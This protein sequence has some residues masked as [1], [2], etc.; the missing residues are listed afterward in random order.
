MAFGSLQHQ[1][2]RLSREPDLARAY[3]DF[4]DIY[5]KLGHMEPVP[6]AEIRNPRA[7]YL[8]HHAVV[9]GTAEKPKI[10]VVFDASRRTRDKHCLNEF[11]MPG[12]ALQ[13]ELPL[14]LLNWRRYKYAFTADIVKMFRQI[15]V[16]P[17]DQDL[18]RILWSPQLGKPAV[19][20]RLRTVT[21]GTAC[22]PYLAMRTLSQL[23]SNERTR[24]PLGAA[25]L[26]L[27]TYVDDTFAG[28]D[29]LAMAIR[30]RD[31]LTDILAS[32]G[33]NLDKWAAN[34]PKLLPAHLQP[35]HNVAIKELDRDNA[36]KTLGVHWSPTCDEFR[37]SASASNTREKTLTK[38]SVYSDIA[39][40]FDPLGWLAPVTVTAKVIMQDLWIE[41][42][43]WD[44][45]LTE[46]VRCR[47]QSY[48]QS[49]S[50]L[51]T[52]TIN[53]W[54]GLSRQ[55][56]FEI[57][58]FSDAS[59]RA[60]AAVTYLRIDNGNGNYQVSLLS[61]KTKVTPVKTVS[62]PNLELCGATLLVKLVVHLQKLDFLQNVPVQLWSDSQIV[63]AWLKKHPCSWKTFVANRVSFIQTELPSATWAYVPTKQNPA[64]LAT[65]GA[66]PD[67]LRSNEL[68]WTGPK[69]LMSPSDKWPQSPKPM[70]SMHSIKTLDEP[71]LLSRY[72]NLTRLVRI[73]AWCLR[74]FLQKIRKRATQGSYP[75]YLTTSDLAN[76]RDAL[77]KLAQ[78]N[79]FSSEIGL[80]QARKSLPKRNH[81]CKLRPFVDIDGI[82]RVGGRLGNAKLPHHLH[83]PAIL[84]RDSTLSR[85]FIS[86]AH[87]RAYHGGPTLTISILLRFAWIVNMRALVKSAIHKCVKCQRHSPR[88]AHQLMGDLP[89]ERVTPARPFTNTG[90]D[91]A[92]PFQLRASKGRGR[93][94]YKG[95]IA[96]FVCFA[97]KALHLEVVGDLTTASFLA[98]YRRF[99]S[100][101]GICKKLFSDNATTFHGAD[102]ELRGMF[103][104][105]SSFY[106][107]ASR[108][109]ANDG[110]EWVFIPPTT[111]HYGGLWEAGV[112]STKHLLK[113]LVGE[114]TLSFEEFSTV[115]AEIE[116]CLNSRPLCQMTA[117][118]EDLQALTPAHFLIGAASGVIPDE[119]SPSA[120]ENRLDRF[121]LLQ[122]IR[123]QFWKRWST[124]YVLLLQGR[125]KWRCPTA[126]FA[127]GQL[128]LIKDDRYPPAKWPLG[129][130]L[131]LHAGADGL[132]R[133]VTLKTAT[134]TLR[135][136]VACLAPLNLS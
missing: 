73:T 62:I 96:L 61:A 44:E 106:T 32:A 118:P 24:F 99:V 76:A 110:T 25:C 108:L 60:Y 88:L 100:R 71:L 6:R 5:L 109:M 46:E 15:Q 36:V 127:I 117:D 59:S 136:H 19:D 95:Y 85:L 132:V 48:C 28:A 98:A 7:W 1:L 31:E 79:A 49:L 116:A 113:K 12:P 43:E 131:E 81:L 41:R 21:Y 129:R 40:L 27:D 55:K 128:V 8:P 92:G 84:P 22:A 93:T 16:A 120:P 91:Y 2:R 50:T 20:Y 11:L 66:S 107:E 58:G 45:P 78:S 123:D 42:C 52:L 72:S 122:R 124:E 30:K 47:W 112:R 82:L 26:E 17:E 9:S 111:P 23:A 75:A 114:R 121:Q 102:A 119:A 94:T 65:R 70:R 133:V 4:M 97:T 125:N 77:V 38:R 130:V 29:D 135:R 39:R 105:A 51:H 64:D 103:K 63:L 14:I 35:N 115:L 13:S 68:W 90:L 67:E 86:H 10:R 87:E 53:R 69:W 74:P 3:T 56:T 104:A 37:F 54:L 89:A 57:H 80:L 126:N 83:F 101:R 134:N 33:I 18:Q 34:H